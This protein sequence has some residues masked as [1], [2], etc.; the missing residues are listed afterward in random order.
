MLAIIYVCFVFTAIFFNFLTVITS[1]YYY[2]SLFSLINQVQLIIL[3]PLIGEFVPSK[4]IDFNR[5]LSSL[6]GSFA[7][8]SKHFIPMFFN[9]IEDYDY[10]QSNWYLYLI[11]IES[12]SSM[13]SISGLI[14]L[15]F[16]MSLIHGFVYVINDVSLEKKDESKCSSAVHSLITWMTIGSYIRLYL[17]SFTF[18]LLISISEVQSKNSRLDYTT[19]YCFAVGVLVF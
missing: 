4:L 2:Q 1:K 3:L 16:I 7:E 14:F 6:M 9:S 13:Y 10:K 5:V 8:I 18:L 19:S 11:H 12:A 17:F 15:L